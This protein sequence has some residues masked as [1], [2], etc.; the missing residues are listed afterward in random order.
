MIAKTS[1]R[2]R[3]AALTSGALLVGGLVAAPVLTGLATASAAPVD[4]SF[5]CTTVSPQG[6]SGPTDRSISVDVTLPASV[7]PGAAL[8]VPVTISV[9]M[10]T[11]STVTS[12]DGT[13]DIP[14]TI[15]D[16]TV[17]ITSAEVSAPVTALKYT[18]SGSGAFTAP[19]TAGSAPVTVGTIVANLKTNPYG[20]AVTSTCVPQG[21]NTVGNLVVGGSTEPT[22]SPT[23]TPTTEPTETPTTEPTDSAACT[24]AQA[25]ADQLQAKAKQAKAKVTKLQK[26][27][28]SATKPAAKKKIKKQLKAAKKNLATVKSDLKGALAAV[29]EAC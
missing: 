17:T 28:K 4:I 15:G 29:D 13:F 22:E 27:L 7:N 18:A 11:A 9:D 12:L 2:G 26:K 6:T 25:A 20:L 1:A 14:L 16:Q 23:T 21:D 10:G 19:A 24:E 3:W 8:T 5:G